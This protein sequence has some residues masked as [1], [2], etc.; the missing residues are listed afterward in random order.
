MNARARLALVC[1]ATIA[2]TL[3]PG[4]L[5]GSAVADPGFGDHVSDCA[6]MQHVGAELNPGLHHGAAGWDGTACH[7]A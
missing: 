5:L 7:V 3:A 4:A 2:L 1:T 6:L